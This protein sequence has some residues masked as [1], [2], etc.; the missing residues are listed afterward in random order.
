MTYK[1]FRVL[2]GQATE[3][4][5]FDMYLAECG[6]QQITDKYW[7]ELDDKLVDDLRLIYDLSKMD[8]KDLRLKLGITQDAMFRAYGI[9]VRTINNWET[10]KRSAAPYIIQLIAYTVFMIFKSTTRM[11]E[12]IDD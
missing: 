6:I 4:T 12:S 10:E 5:D 3:Y 8:F 7:D 1:D 2:Y 11:L 9:P